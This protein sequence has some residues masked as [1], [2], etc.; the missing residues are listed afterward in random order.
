MNTS[1]ITVVVPT[2][3]EARN[4]PLFLAS[5]PETCHL[6]VVDT[7][8]DNTPELIRINR[9]NR[10]RIL[11]QQS[12][13]PEARQAGAELATTEWLL[14]T[15]A[16]VV[17]PTGYFNCLKSYDTYDCI[18]GSKLSTTRY[19]QYYRYFAYAQHLSHRIG[20]P[21]ATG[22]NLLV[23]RNIVSDVGGFD[24][25]LVCN[26]DSELVWRI[27]KAGYTVCY[28]PG[29]AVLATDHRR[30]ERGLCRKTI[31]SLMR[32]SLLYFNLIPEKWRGRDWGYWSESKNDD[33]HPT[34]S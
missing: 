31:H 22:S 25:N 16:D 17:F 12:N 7:S 27:K 30:L 18:Y 32:C 2:R 34:E 19:K 29:L 26:E 8:D 21:A 14:F 3:N 23:K 24:P 28:A 1:D 10:T 4:I 13:I 5:L 15:D 33:R 9:P 20:I 11:R 6:I